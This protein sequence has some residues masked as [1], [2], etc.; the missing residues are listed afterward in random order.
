MELVCCF[1]GAF[2]FLPLCS[3]DCICQLWFTKFAN[4]Q[5]AGLPELTFE[6]VLTFTE[7]D[8]QMSSAWGLRN[9]KAQ[10]AMKVVKCARKTLEE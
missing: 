8:Q 1:S 2:F 3:N 6:R 4:I 5:V 7:V 9:H 10:N